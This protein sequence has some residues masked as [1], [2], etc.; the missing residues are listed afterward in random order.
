MWLMKWLRK[1]KYKPTFVLDIDY[2][3]ETHSLRLLL[4][5]KKGILM[6]PGDT[7]NIQLSYE[8]IER[9]IENT[10]RNS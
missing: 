9:A 2:D 4:D 6:L 7:L 10:K 8:D 1:E 5:P 3:V